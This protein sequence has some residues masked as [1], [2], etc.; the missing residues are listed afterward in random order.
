MEFYKLLSLSVCVGLLYEVSC[1]SLYKESPRFVNL[2]DCGE[3]LVDHNPHA[4]VCDF[5]LTSL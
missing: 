4:E 1:L 2:R 5:E 3:I